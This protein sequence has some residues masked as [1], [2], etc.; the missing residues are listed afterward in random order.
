MS[1]G[2]HPQRSRRRAAQ[3]TPGTAESAQTAAAVNRAQPNRQKR[4]ADQL[5][6]SSLYTENIS[7][8]FAEVHAN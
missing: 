1:T 3:V 4:T 6:V 5:L 2:R 7:T 8:C